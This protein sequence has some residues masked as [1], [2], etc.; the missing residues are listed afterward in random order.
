MA[1]TRIPIPDWARKQEA[2]DRLELPLAEI[3]LSVRTV[4]C[5][6]DESIFTVKDLLACTPQRL[7]EIPNFGVR[8][9][10]SVYEALEKVRFYRRSRRAGDR[11]EGEYVLLGE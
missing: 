5:L 2:D 10:Q 3:E 11:W 8:T 9:L 1:V 6:E 7:M 4:N